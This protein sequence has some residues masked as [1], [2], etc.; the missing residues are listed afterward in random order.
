MRKE[1]G[2]RNLELCK[3][4]LD[5]G[6]YNDWV[7]TTAFY[8]AVH[9]V[10]H[11][12][13]PLIENGVEYLTYNEYWQIFFHPRHISKHDGKKRL[14]KQYIPTVKNQYRELCDDCNN[15]RYNDYNVS[16]YNAKEAIKKAQ[17]IKKACLA[18]KP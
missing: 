2:S 6:Q 17:A 4:L 12:L 15:S 1:H 13:F 11:A 9:F 10:E 8:S 5:D 3:L 16:D 18:I 14:V 7:V